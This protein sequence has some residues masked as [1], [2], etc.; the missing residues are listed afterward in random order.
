M[1]TFYA[2]LLI[3]ISSFYLFSQDLTVSEIIGKYEDTMKHK[4]ESIEARITTTDNFGTT[5]RTFQI[6]SRENGDTLIIITDGPDKGQKILRLENSIFLFYP[7]AE[8]VIRLTGSALKENIAGTDFSYEDLSGSV[9]IETSYNVL[10][11]G[12]EE[13][14]SQSCYVLELNAKMKTQAKTDLIY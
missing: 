3:V 4:T 13:I 1:K 5:H 12:M 6:Y 7:S 8:E 11:K 10:Y 14:N 2:A 9:S